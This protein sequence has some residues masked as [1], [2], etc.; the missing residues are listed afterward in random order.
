MV[1]NDIRNIVYNCSDSTYDK[2]SL[3][4]L[5]DLVKISHKKRGEKMRTS[6]I[7]F[8][9]IFLVIGGLFYFMPMQ[10]FSA[11]T[12]TTESGS[13]TDV[14]TSSASV[15]IP[16]EWA[17]ASGIIGFIFLLLGLAI[18]GRA[19]AVQGPAVQGP[20]GP[21]GRVS[22]KKQAPKRR[23]KAALPKGTSVTRTTKTVRK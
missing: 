11:G 17:Y 2:K 15:N 19:N 22:A 7:V 23:R 18:P 13:A 8:G 21:R 6:L 9:V 1:S 4:F 14:R 3:T 10:Q 16:V 20:R 5:L 12:T